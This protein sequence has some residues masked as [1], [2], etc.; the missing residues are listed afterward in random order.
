MGNY[1]THDFEN[2]CDPDCSICGYSRESKHT[3]QEEWVQDADN[4]WHVCTGC[5]LKEG[6]AVHEPGAEATATTNQVCTICNYEIA[7]VLGIEET[8]QASEKTNTAENQSNAVNF[9]SLFW[10]IVIIGIAA[11]G[12]T[13]TVAASKKRKSKI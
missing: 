13:I 3:F 2:N 11:I 6:E 5:G 10:I 4:H 9:D 12:V 1:E 8:T 7:P